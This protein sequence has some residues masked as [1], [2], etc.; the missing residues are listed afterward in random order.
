LS[1]HHLQGSGLE[2]VDK[3]ISFR[4]CFWCHIS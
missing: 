3:F 4:S 2:R 1:A